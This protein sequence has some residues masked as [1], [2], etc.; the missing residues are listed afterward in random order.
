MTTKTSMIGGI[1]DTIYYYDTTKV[2]CKAP[3]DRGDIT[4]IKPAITLHG[5]G[6]IQADRC[7][8]SGFMLCMRGRNLDSFVFFFTPGSQQ[9]RL[10]TDT[11]HQ[12]QLKYPGNCY[13]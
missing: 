10:H 4:G 6:F 11:D 2:C 12:Y 13:L 3:A 8:G 1:P 9:Q 7:D 5:K